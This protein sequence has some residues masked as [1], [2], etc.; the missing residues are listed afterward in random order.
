MKIG[1]FLMTKK[2]FAVLSSLIEN[3][4]YN[5][6]DFVCIGKD[7][8]LN[9]DYSLA[10]ENICRENNILFCFKDTIDVKKINSDYYIA[11]SWRWIIEMPNLIILHD[12]ILPKYRGF[13]PLVNM[14]INGEKEFGV[15][16]IFA[17]DQYDQGDIILQEKVNINY[18]IKIAEIIDEISNLY[19]LIVYNLFDCILNNEKLIGI[20]QEEK[21][22]SYS[23]WLDDEDYFIDW[24]I[25][26]EKIRRKVDACGSPYEG[27]K[28]WLNDEIIIIKEVLPIDDIK[29]E[30]RASGK[31][32]FMKDIY[33]VVVCG[34]GLLMIKEAVTQDGFNILPLKKFRTRFK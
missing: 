21:Y 8:N 18:P 27:A 33:P 28:C 10:I 4:K 25:S 20:K 14:L 7:A 9:D 13:A 17:N 24:N 11:V 15:T 3:K 22:T 29:I 23:L 6:I 32:I 31:V 12:S 26:A 2:G 19:V 30:N 5:V 34:S 16:A 1:L